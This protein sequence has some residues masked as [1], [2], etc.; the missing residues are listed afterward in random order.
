MKQT[1]KN[2]LA[3]ALYKKLEEH[4]TNDH[5]RQV[6]DLR[7]NQNGFLV[8]HRTMEYLKAGQL[9]LRPKRIGE[10]CALLGL[11]FYLKEVYFADFVEKE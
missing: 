10:I 1:T 9:C 5:K 6:S 8:S 2:D 11:N 7:G 4:L 3:K